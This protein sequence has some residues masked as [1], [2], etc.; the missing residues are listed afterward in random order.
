MRRAPLLAL[1]ALLA[2]GCTCGQPAVEPPADV[3]TADAGPRCSADADCKRGYACVDGDCAPT[4]PEGHACGGAPSAPTCASATTLRTTSAGTCVS[5][6]CHFATTD[7]PCAHG[8]ASGACEACTPACGASVCGDDGCGGSCGGCPSGQWCGGGG[9]P[10][11]CGASSTIAPY[12]SIAETQVDPGA[13]LGLRVAPDERHVLVERALN[14]G[15]P[16]SSFSQCAL[17]VV[18]LGASGAGTARELSA[19][20]WMDNGNPL[21]DF[22]SDS[23][24]LYFYDATAT[25]VQLVVANADGSAARTLASHVNQVARLG[26]DSLVYVVT[27]AA[28]DG[29]DEVWAVQ[30]PAGAPVKLAAAGSV[31]YPMAFPN[32]TGTAAMVTDENGARLLAQTATGASAAFG[33]GVMYYLGATWSPDGAHVAYWSNNDT[34]WKLHVL[35][36]DGTGDALLSSKVATSVAFPPDGSAIAYGELDYSTGK[37]GSLTVHPFGG[38]ADAVI[39][40][41]G[42]TGTSLAFSA[43][44]QRLFFGSGSTLGAASS[45]QSGTL[46]VIDAHAS[47]PFGPLD[48]PQFAVSPDHAWAAVVE[49]NRTISVVPTSGGAGQALALPGDYLPFYEPAAAEARL[50]VFTSPTPSESGVEGALAIFAG[51]GTGAGA[52]LPGKALPAITQ[53]QVTHAQPYGWTGPDGGG[54]QVAEP[55]TYGWLGSVAVYETNRGQNGTTAQ[56]VVAAT[57]DGGTVGVIAAGAG[58]WAVR[59][60]AAATRLFFTRPGQQGVWTVPVPRTPGR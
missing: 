20:A 38:G 24:A 1:F 13:A 27:S 59:D 43:D 47:P 11:Q 29:D 48:P 30:L 2:A 16:T 14:P 56:D 6:A 3:G 12:P 50:L 40:T 57:D 54:G 8:C 28:N 23:S 4:C 22:T 34:A 10:G 18:T 17:A 19:A 25:P 46:T 44:G 41:G 32:A 15:S 52:R 31:H 9:T 35:A 33:A 21:A 53:A 55:F 60:G 5:G 51:D 37:V 39:A 45:T 36:A 42:I 49:T 58:V 7:V 26:G